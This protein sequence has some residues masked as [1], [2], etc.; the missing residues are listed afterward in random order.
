[1]HFDVQPLKEDD[2]RNKARR[3]SVRLMLPFMYMKYQLF[4][5]YL[6]GYMVKLT[7]YFGDVQ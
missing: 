2:L 3:H 1:M 7:A 4:H 5:F 6:T